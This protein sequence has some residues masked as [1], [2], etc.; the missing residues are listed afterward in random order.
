MDNFLGHLSTFVGGVVGGGVGFLFLGLVLLAVIIPIAMWTHDKN[1]PVKHTG[2]ERFRA[3]LDTPD[4]GYSDRIPTKQDSED[5]RIENERRAHS[6]LGE[7][8]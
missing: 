5:E 7:P 4:V 6:P 2:L 1:A 3:S 8:T